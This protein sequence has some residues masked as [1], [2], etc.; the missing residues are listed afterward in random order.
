MTELRP[1]LV[2][3]CFLCCACNTL[4]CV[5]LQSFLLLLNLICSF[6]HVAIFSVCFGCVFAAVIVDFASFLV[7]VFAG[8]ASVAVVLHLGIVTIS[9]LNF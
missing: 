5:V 4:N 8:R 3:F 1:W 2:G 9:F 6:I 7:Y